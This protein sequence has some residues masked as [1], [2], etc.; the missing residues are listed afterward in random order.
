MRENK[1]ERG[2]EWKGRYQSGEGER[3]KPSDITESTIRNK[4]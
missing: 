1:K 3:A 2:L 4:R